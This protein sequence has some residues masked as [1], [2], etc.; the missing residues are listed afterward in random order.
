MIAILSLLKISLTEMHVNVVEKWRE[1]ERVSNSKG[2]RARECIKTHNLF[3]NNYGRIKAMKNNRKMNSPI[4]GALLIK[5]KQSQV[6]K[7]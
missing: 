1:K 7:I 5:W 4:N 2:I 6:N 3:Q